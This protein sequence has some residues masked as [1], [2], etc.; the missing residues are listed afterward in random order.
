[1]SDNVTKSLRSFRIGSIS[2]PSTQLQIVIEL[3]ASELSNTTYRTN[4]FF[5]SLTLDITRVLLFRKHACV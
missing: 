3:L 1:M 2:K 5:V 4:S